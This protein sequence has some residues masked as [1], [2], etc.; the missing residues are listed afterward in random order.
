MVQNVFDEM[1]KLSGAVELLAHDSEKLIVD[2]PKRFPIGAV[3]AFFQ[4]F[5]AL[6]QV[7]VMLL[8][9]L[10]QVVHAFIIN[11]DGL[12]DGWTSNRLA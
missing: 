5:T 2:H 3:A 12:D 10:P 1:I 4:K 6:F 9:C 7:L 8:D 11:G